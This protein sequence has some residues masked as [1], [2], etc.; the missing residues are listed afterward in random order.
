VNWSLSFAPLIPLPWLA[1]FAVIGVV[2]A[3]LMLMRRLR[4]V[5]LRIAALA[6]LLFAL[7]GPVVLKEDRQALPTVV[8]MVV[9]QTASQSLDGRDA[10][11]A[12]MRTALQKRFGD[13]RNIELRTVEVGGKSNAAPIDGTELFKAVATEL[14]DVA[15]D[16]IGAVIMLTDGQVHDVPPTA[17]ALGGAPLHA[18]ISGHD[19]EVDRRL[20]IHASPRFGIVG[21]TQTSNTASK[22][23]ASPIL[24]RSKSR[25]ASMACPLRRR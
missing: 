10:A 21:Q 8:A 13:L 9:D 19:N 16:R 24:R 7:T 22:M 25:S 1:A 6:A 11:T 20:I 17:E 4:G 14:A 23:M 2:V 3:G 12:A 18:L 5:W 15:P